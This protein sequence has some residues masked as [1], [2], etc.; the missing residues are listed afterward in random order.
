MESNRLSAAQAAAEIRVG[1]LTAERLVRDC[2]ERI[3]ARDAEIGAWAYCDPAAAIAQAR[4]VDR[5]G[6]G[7]PLAGVPVGFKDVIDTADMPSEYNSPA[8]RGHRPRADAAC[9]SL[10]RSAGGIVLGKTVTT[11]FAWK[12][13]AATRNPHNPAY[14]PGGSSSGSAAAVADFMVPLAFGTQTGG[15]TIRPAAFCGIV[16]YK[17]SFGLVNRAGLKP[18]AESL[19]TIGILA[20]TV[21]DCALLAHVVSDLA[22]PEFDL[23]SAPRIALCRT[24]RWKDATRETHALLEGAAGLLSGNGARVRD[25]ELPAEFDRLYEEQVLIM[26]YEGARALAWERAAHPELLSGEAREAF[27]ASA[28]LPREEYEAAMHHASRCRALAVQLFADCDV[29]L[30]PSAPGEAP[31]GFSTTGSSLFNRIWT[32]LGLPCVTVPAGRGAA[33]LPLGVQLVAAYGEDGRALA[34]GEWVRRALGGLPS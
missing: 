10:V 28:A 31:A 18:L 13:P 23:A 34:C 24:P 21:E 3:A 7:G 4:A 1:R 26:N 20:R 9:A 17:P 29:L 6:A 30:T 15:S 8:W 19:D 16:G 22:L 11:E 2:L 27:A 32:L 14:S 33:G 5:A 12:V 25:L